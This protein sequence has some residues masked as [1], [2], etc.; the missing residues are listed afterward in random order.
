MIEKVDES[1]QINLEKQGRYLLDWT[2]KNITP[3]LNSEDRT[4]I[5]KNKQNLEYS[6]NSHRLQPEKTASGLRRV[7][8]DESFKVP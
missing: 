2:D 1:N 6:K 3:T 5:L 7:P 4:I 8:L